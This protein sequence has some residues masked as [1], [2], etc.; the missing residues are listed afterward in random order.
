MKVSVVTGDIAR[1]SADAI[2]VDVFEGAAHPSGATIAVDELLKGAIAQMISQNEVKGKVG[3][4][5]LIHTLGKL[6]AAR[7]AVLGLGKQAELNTD[8]VRRAMAECCRVLR[9]A[10]AQKIA[11]VIHGTKD[12]ALPVSEAVQ[13]TAEGCILGL[14]TFRKY[15]T[16]APEEPQVEEVHIV[17]TEADASALE[18]ACERGSIIAEATN[19]ARSM[20]NEPSNR[21]TPAEMAEIAHDLA[22]SYGLQVR[23]LHREQM[24]A[25]GMGALLGVAQGAA[26]P[27]AFILLRYNGNPQS[28]EVL[29]LVGKGITFDS[30]GISLKP[31]EGMEEMKDDMSGGAIVMNAIAAISRLRLKANVIAMC[32][33]TEN[34][35]SGTALKP[36][37]VLKALNGKTI[38]VISTD[39]EGRLTL[40]D[41]LSYAVREGFS[42]I[43]DVATLTGACRVAL[44]QVATGLF[45]NNQELANKVLEAAAKAGEKMWQMPMFEEYKEQNKSDIAD[46]KNSGGRYG[47]AITAAQFLSEFV[48]VTPWV[49]LDIAGTAFTEKVSGYNV[50]GATGVAVRTLVNLVE[51]LAA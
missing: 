2:I 8:K 39:A 10:G 33:A 45:T 16:K 49:H 46:M 38:E 47:G 44:G 28:S 11:S 25:K 34:L 27:P 30:G 22:R 32:G 41:V 29:A 12:G 26:Q 19:L 15:C 18:R 21:M 3:E 40:A 14:Y 50:K 35:P 48:G 37:D 24:R 23:V 42:P 43:V 6:P 51:S 1:Y 13:A 17:S 36:G 4:V 7:V 20:I 5:T 9:R 31:S